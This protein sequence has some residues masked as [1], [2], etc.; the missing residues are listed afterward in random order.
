MRR[1]GGGETVLVRDGRDDLVIDAVSI[2]LVEVGLEDDVQR[3]RELI[4]S[5]SSDDK[6]H[7]ACEVAIAWIRFA[8]DLK[9][10]LREKRMNGYL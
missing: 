8:Q 7:T 4:E 9:H 5:G 3:L 10:E 6:M 1:V 2:G